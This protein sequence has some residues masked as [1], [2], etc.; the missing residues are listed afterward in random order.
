M[1]KNFLGLLAIGIVISAVCLGFSQ[2]RAEDAQEQGIL[3]GGC[4]C[5][6]VGKVISHEGLKTYT[7]NGN[8]LQGVATGAMGCEEF[9]VWRTS[10]EVGG[11]TPMHVHATEEIF[12]FLKGK[13]RA[14][15]GGE[16]F[17]FEAPCTIICPANVPHQLFNAGDEPTDSILVMGVGSKIRDMNGKEMK[18]PWRN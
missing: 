11:A 18:L 4:T 17:E 10:W 16:E 7:F 14:I 13:G 3:P 12:I 15:I 9:E 8:V 1:K 5:P 6:A 2:A